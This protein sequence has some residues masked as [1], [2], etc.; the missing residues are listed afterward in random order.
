MQKGINL[1]EIEWRLLKI[2]KKDAYLHVFSS[3]EEE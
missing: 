3:F 2:D 1:E